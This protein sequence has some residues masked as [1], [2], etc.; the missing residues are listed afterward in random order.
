MLDGTSC[1]GMENFTAVRLKMASS[2]LI[3]GHIKS[4][5]YAGCVIIAQ[6][7]TRIQL[8]NIW[9]RSNHPS[10][11]CNSAK[12]NLYIARQ[13]EIVNKLLLIVWYLVLVV[14]MSCN[15]YLKFLVEFASLFVVHH[16]NAFVIAV[17]VGFIKVHGRRFW[18]ATCENFKIPA[19]NWCKE[20]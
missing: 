5:S 11:K 6:Q 2:E 7:S 8:M 13:D 19:S 17:D 16:G 18:N 1:G 4:Q 14:K 10:S 3:L 20:N 15:E 12:K 9:V